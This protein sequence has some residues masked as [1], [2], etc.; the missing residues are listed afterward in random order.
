MDRLT[1]EETPVVKAKAHQHAVRK[2]ECDRI[3]NKTRINI[4]RAFEQWRQLRELKGFKSDPELAFFL[5]DTVD[6]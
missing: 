3:R 5:L 4:G 1:S 2:R 6:G